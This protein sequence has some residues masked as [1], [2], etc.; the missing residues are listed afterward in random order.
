[1]SVRLSA[2]EQSLLSYLATV[3]GSD[4]Y[5]YVDAVDGRI[6]EAHGLVTIVKAVAPPKSVHA[7]QPYYGVTISAAGRDF[8]ANTM[9]RKSV[10]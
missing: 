10:A 6:L 9:P 1:M 2:R 4:I 7:K 8:I 5:N 3:P